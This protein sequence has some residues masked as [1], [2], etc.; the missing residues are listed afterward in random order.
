MLIH[1]NLVHLSLYHNNI[2]IIE[3]LG[4]EAILSLIGSVVVSILKHCNLKINPS[5]PKKVV[6]KNSAS[7]NKQTVQGLVDLLLNINDN[8]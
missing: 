1:I 2:T 6:F 5:T 3:L 7:T 8:I 4:I